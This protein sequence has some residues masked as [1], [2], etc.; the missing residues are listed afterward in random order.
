MPQ[1]IVQKGAYSYRS[2]Q[3]KREGKSEAAVVARSSE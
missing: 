1:K 3:L 2:A